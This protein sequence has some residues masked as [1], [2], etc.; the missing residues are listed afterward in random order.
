MPPYWGSY[1]EAITGVISERPPRRLLKGVPGIPQG[2][3]LFYETFSSQLL[4]MGFSPSKADCCLFI[5]PGKEFT[6]VV[7]WVDDFVFVHEKEATWQ[8]FIGQLRQRFTVPAAGPLT[9]FLGMEIEYDPKAHFMYLSQANTIEVLLERARMADCNPVPVPCSSGAVFSKKDCPTP[10]SPR[11]TDYAS[12]VALANFLACWTRPDIVFIVNKLCKFMSNPGDVHW[13]MLKFLLR[14]LKG[15][16]QKGL[17]YKFDVASSPK[18]VH[19]YAA[20]H[21]PTAWTLAAAR[22]PMCFIMMVRS[23][24]VQQIAF[25]CYHLHHPLRI[26]CPVRRCSVAGVFIL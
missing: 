18:G 25:L 26:R 19:G 17:L 5:K 4:L 12:L 23:C 10:P 7:V 9:S 8:D 16:K 21:M 20:L 2:S 22:L 15:S 1:D 11:A 6:A 14:Y 13:Q 3:R 24:P